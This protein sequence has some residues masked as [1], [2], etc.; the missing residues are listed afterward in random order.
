MPPPPGFHTWLKIVNRSDWPI[1]IEGGITFPYA[2]ASTSYMRAHLLDKIQPNNTATVKGVAVGIS[3]GSQGAPPTQGSIRIWSVDIQGIRLAQNKLVPIDGTSIHFQSTDSRAPKG[4]V[5]LQFNAAQAL[6]TIETS[7][8]PSTL[9]GAAYTLT[10]TSQKPVT[11]LLWFTGSNEATGQS[12]ESMHGNDAP[13]DGCGSTSALQLQRYV[14]GGG[15]SNPWAHM[16]LLDHTL[17]TTLSSLAEGT[18]FGV[19]LAYGTCCSSDPKCTATFC[20][21]VVLG[22]TST[23]VVSNA[24][25]CTP[26]NTGYLLTEDG[27]QYSTSPNHLFVLSSAPT[28]PVSTNTVPLQWC[29]H[30]D[31]FWYSQPM[32]LLRLQ[33]DGGYTGLG[34]QTNRGS[35]PQ[36]LPLPAGQALPTGMARAKVRMRMYGEKVTPKLLPVHTPQ[37]CSTGLTRT[38]WLS[39]RRP[40]HG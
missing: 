13:L 5:S 33:D 17:T 8:F 31:G 14:N 9:G 28:A 37:Q 39:G 21:C 15:D 12:W 16:F 36:I 25:R 11:D 10:W 24:S 22:K 34:I 3:G 7:G 27:L 40:L 4:E 32:Y 1:G 35:N 20:K 29:K 2:S 23:C 26:Q 18:P 19:R 38:F 30:D 6:L